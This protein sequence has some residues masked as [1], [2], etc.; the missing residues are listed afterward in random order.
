MA[1]TRPLA[2]C[3]TRPQAVSTA[4]RLII[5]QFAAIMCS[6]VTNSFTFSQQSRQSCERLCRSILQG[7]WHAFRHCRHEDDAEHE[8]SLFPM[9]VNM[10]GP[11]NPPLTLGE[12]T[13]TALFHLK[14]FQKKLQPTELRKTRGLPSQRS[15]KRIGSSKRTHRFCSNNERQLPRCQQ[16]RVLNKQYVILNVFQNQKDQHPGNEAQRQ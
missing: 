5:T 7:N 13:K 6:N 10:P 8:T 2:R 12:G 4:R 16:H 9:H 3:T 14:L 1:S 15:C 11:A